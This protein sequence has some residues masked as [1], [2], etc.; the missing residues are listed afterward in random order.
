MTE[1]RTALLD[2]PKIVPTLPR[3]LSYDEV[4]RW[5]ATTQA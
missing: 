2:R 4:E 5:G 1:D 3:A